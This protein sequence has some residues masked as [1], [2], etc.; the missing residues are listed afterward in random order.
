MKSIQLIKVIKGKKPTP[1]EAGF[2]LLIDDS[3]HYLLIDDASH[4]LLLQS[5]A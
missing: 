3:N 2:F 4:K 1:P 5:G